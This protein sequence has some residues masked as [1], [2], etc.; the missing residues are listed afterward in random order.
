MLIECLFPLLF[1]IIASISYPPC[2]PVKY[3]CNLKTANNTSRSMIPACLKASRIIE[4]AD[5]IGRATVAKAIDINI[6][7]GQP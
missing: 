1:S 7:G 5:I 6:M 4:P 3:G 2:T